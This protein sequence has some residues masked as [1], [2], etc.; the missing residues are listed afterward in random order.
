MVVPR[1]RLGAS[2]ALAFLMFASGAAA[3]VGSLPEH[4]S[5]RDLEPIRARL[6]TR[7][8]FARLDSVPPARAFRLESGAPRASGQIEAASLDEYVRVAELTARPRQALS[9]MWQ[10][11][12]RSPWVRASG[13]SGAVR[14]SW[15]R[16]SSR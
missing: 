16:Y 10:I 1:R 5:E 4:P 12:A 14:R 15:R 6:S 13:W 11:L 9:R 2:V 8:L 3:P 7:A